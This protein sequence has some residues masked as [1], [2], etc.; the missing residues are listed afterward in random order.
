MKV[1]PKRPDEG[2]KLGA[3]ERLVTNHVLVNY[4]PFKV[5]QY[6]VAITRFGDRK[7]KEDAPKKESKDRGVSLK[8][9]WFFAYYAREYKRGVEQFSAI[10]FLMH[11]MKRLF[12]HK[13]FCREDLMLVFMEFVSRF[14]NVFG[15]AKTAQSRLVYDRVKFLYTYPPLNMDGKVVQMFQCNAETLKVI[16]QT[17]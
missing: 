8:K 6:D 4:N 11:S 7:R 15:D 2:G 12:M 13:H 3:K 9:R 16:F 5:H 10:R 14:P 17:V 1:L